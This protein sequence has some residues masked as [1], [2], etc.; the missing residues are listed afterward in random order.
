MLSENI[1]GSKPHLDG[2]VGNRRLRVMLD[3][4]C[5]C[6]CKLEKRI[7]IL[8]RGGLVNIVERVDHVLGHAGVRVHQ[9]VG[10]GVAVDFTATITGQCETALGQVLAPRTEER[11]QPTRSDCFQQ[12]GVCEF[13]EVERHYS[14]PPWRVCARE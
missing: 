2:N 12:I 3:L 13:P 7:H 10:Q 8:I 1:R 4:D 5:P 14:I 11:D 9:D 6:F